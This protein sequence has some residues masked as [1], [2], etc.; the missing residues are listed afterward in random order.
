MGEKG[1][2]KEKSRSTQNKAIEVL[3]KDSIEN[4]ENSFIFKVNFDKDEGNGRMRID[5]HTKQCQ[6]QVIRD[7]ITTPNKE[8]S[9]RSSK[10][11][12]TST[13]IMSSPFTPDGKKK[14]QYTKGI[15]SS[16]TTEV[17]NFLN[18]D[19]IMDSVVDILILEDKDLDLLSKELIQVFSWDNIDDSSDVQKG[20]LI[21]KILKL[22]GDNYLVEDLRRDLLKI[23]IEDKMGGHTKIC[24][25]LIEHEVK[26]IERDSMEGIY[27]KIGEK[28][29]IIHQIISELNNVRNGRKKWTYIIYC[30]K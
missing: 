18:K 8:V 15:D 21:Q 4:L 22:G 24:G 9:I 17:Q 19:I 23:E 13:A 27:G 16:L 7:M 10:F 1:L 26:G 3:G 30:S 11:W 2:D 12:Q 25:N 5:R 28:L 14:D 20:E 6:K 29:S